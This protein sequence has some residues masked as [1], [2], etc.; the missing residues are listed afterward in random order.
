MKKVLSIVSAIL[1][2]ILTLSAVSMQAFASEP[3]DLTQFGQDVYKTIGNY[4]ATDDM[5]IDG[6]IDPEEGWVCVTPEF[7]D[8]ARANGLTNKYTGW[9]W[10]AGK[11][12][13]VSEDPMDPCTSDFKYYV[14]QSEDKIYIAFEDYSAFVDKNGNGIMDGPEEGMLRNNYF[15]KFGFNPD[16]YSQLFSTLQ[17]GVEIDYLAGSKAEGKYDNGITV[18]SVITAVASATYHLTTTEF[19]AEGDVINYDIYE[20]KNISGKPTAHWKG[21]IE[22]EFDKENIKAAYKEVFDVELTDEDFATIYLG[23]QAT[24][25]EGVTATGKGYMIYGTLL[26]ADTANANN[27]P[28]TYIPDLIVFD[29]FEV[30]TTEAPTTEPEV[31]EAPVAD[32]EATEVEATEPEVT[33]AIDE[34]NVESGC[35]SSVSFVALALVATVGTCTAFVAKKKED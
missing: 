26:D 35:A 19:G 11:I 28:S 32:T 34:E 8:K 14:A 23:I 2:L 29:E 27:L 24:A 7:V 20:N 17:K 9:G 16:D 33:E 10:D 15:F 3:A 25:Y 31:T 4:T 1:V 30:P 18:K 6:C 12:L 5:S 21:Q 22:Y 13:Q